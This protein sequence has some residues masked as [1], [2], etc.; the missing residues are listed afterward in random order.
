MKEE[1]KSED[2]I[3]IREAL[4]KTQSNV[5]VPHGKSSQ[6]LFFGRFKGLGNIANKKIWIEGI[7]ELCFH[8]PFTLLSGCCQRA[9]KKDRKPKACQCDLNLAA[10]SKNNLLTTFSLTNRGM[11]KLGV[12]LPKFQDKIFAPSDASFKRGMDHADTQ[13]DLKDP[14]KDKWEPTYQN[15]VHFVLLVSYEDTPSKNLESLFSST[16]SSWGELVFSQYGARR[17]LNEK[18]KKYP[19]EWF[20]FRDG[21]S[22]LHLWGKYDKKVSIRNLSILLDEDFGSYMV[23]RKYEQHVKNFNERVRAL[24]KEI[25]KH[26]SLEKHFLDSEIPQKLIEFCEAQVIGRFKDGTPL[27]NYPRSLS[28]RGKSLKE[29]DQICTLFNTY[30]PNSWEKTV[31]D[32]LGSYLRE[33]PGLKCPHH[34][35]IRKTNPRNKALSINLNYGGEDI[36]SEARIARRGITYDDREIQS[37]NEEPNRDIGLLFIS[38]Q[39]SIRRQF[40]V[41][42]RNWVNAKSFPGSGDVNEHQIT[43]GV[44]PLIGVLDDQTPQLWNKN[45]NQPESDKLPVAFNPTTSP[46]LTTLKGGYY[47]YSPSISWIKRLLDIS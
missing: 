15:E 24:A 28:D 8:S 30:P 31:N 39:N 1:K 42:V 36:I 22:R 40:E 38:Y 7:N 20:G 33:E 44:D 11:E 32:K 26:V 2:F 45:W 23:L 10:K 12:Y 3:W 47:L 13:T 46:P 4:Q 16:I 18:S 17:Y 37:A 29:I 35:H 27:S 19:I 43:E 34:A 25:H 9:I 14:K 41:I 6:V 21:L 5:L